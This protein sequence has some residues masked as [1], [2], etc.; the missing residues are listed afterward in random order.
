MTEQ[1]QHLVQLVEQ[2]KVLIQEIEKLSAEAMTKKELA[3]K[4]Q[5]AV[6]YLNQVGVFLPE[7][8]S[9]EKQE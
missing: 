6:E 9:E 5:G 4:L 8:K 1:Q 3:L 2:Q 7:E